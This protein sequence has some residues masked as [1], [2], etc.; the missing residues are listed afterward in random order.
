MIKTNVEYKWG[1]RE[2]DSFI[3]I[4]DEI[5]QAP[6]LMSPYFSKDFILYTFTYDMSLQLS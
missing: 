2:K 5:T 6:A 4:K 3:N 1:P